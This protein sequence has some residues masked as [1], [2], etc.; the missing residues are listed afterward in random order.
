VR[1]MR[2]DSAG[3]EL[4]DVASLLAAGLDHRQHR[5]H[6]TPARRVSAATCVWAEQACRADAACLRATRSLATF[7]LST[8]AYAG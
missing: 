5:C 4:Q 1:K 2:L 6:K 8:A 7:S 3:K